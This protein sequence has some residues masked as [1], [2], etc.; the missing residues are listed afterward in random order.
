MAIKK[1]FAMH[2]FVEYGLETG[3][4]L[5]SFL[6]Y[7]ICLI[8]ITDILVFCMTSLDLHFKFKILIILEGPT[9][10]LN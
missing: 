4:A 5:T 1:F 3:P 6:M 2:S 8:A 7:L 10:Y 9:D